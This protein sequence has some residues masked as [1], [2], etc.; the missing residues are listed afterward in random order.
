MGGMEETRG[1]RHCWGHGWRVLLER[2]ASCQG[3]DVSED[4]CNPWETYAG[5]VTPLKRLCT[6]DDTHQSRDTPEETVACWQPV[7]EHGHP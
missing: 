2:G 3:R 5:A 7:P 4:E 6:M 1:R